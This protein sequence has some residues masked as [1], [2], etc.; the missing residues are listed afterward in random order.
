MQVGCGYIGQDELTKQK[1]VDVQKTFPN[2]GLFH[3]L[4]QL[5]LATKSPANAFLRLYR[6]GIT[7]NVVLQICERLTVALMS[8]FVVTVR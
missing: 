8:T 3:Y 5:T 6:T 4:Q 2:S 1:F 7:K